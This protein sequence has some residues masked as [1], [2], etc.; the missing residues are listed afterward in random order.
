MK[1]DSIDN[2]DTSYPIDKSDTDNKLSSLLPP[3]WSSVKRLNKKNYDYNYRNKAYIIN[4]WDYLQRMTLYK[5]LIEN[6]YHCEFHNNDNDHYYSFNDGMNGHYRD[7]DSNVEDIIN[8]GNILWGLVL[9]H[10]WQYS[11]GRL[12]LN[13]NNSLYLSSSSSSQ[14]FTSESTM[15]DYNAW[16]GDMNYYLSVI[17]YLGAMEAGLVPRIMIESIHKHH[18]SHHYDDDDD[19]VKH[20]NNND[21]DKI[22]SLF[23]RSYDDCKAVIDPWIQFF[24]LLNKTSDSCSSSSS[25]SSSNTAT[26]H[27]KSSK[28]LVEKDNN[29]NNGNDNNNNINNNDSKGKIESLYFHDFKTPIADLI[30]FNLT[31]GRIL[32]YA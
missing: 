18:H 14:S 12:Q 31:D 24:Q 8:P 17:P 30:D 11:S 5:Y 19:D 23:C 13:K 22:N 3:L 25:S 28:M 2:S 21:N 27:S 29:N 20:D 4:V 16:W 1:Y 32:I 15:I 9:Q 7:S 10:G 26:F 6:L